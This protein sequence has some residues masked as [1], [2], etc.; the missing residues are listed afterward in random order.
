MGYIVLFPSFRLVGSFLFIPAVRL[1]GFI[2]FICFKYSL[3]LLQFIYS[4][5]FL[6]IYSNLFIPIYLFQSPRGISTFIIDFFQWSKAPPTTMSW[7]FIFIFLY[8]FILICAIYQRYTT[9][10]GWYG[11]KVY[12]VSNPRLGIIWIFTIFFQVFL[13]HCVLATFYGYFVLILL[14]F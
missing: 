2:S 8:V 7:R 5:L 14:Y 3:P 6:F 10:W 1:V 9:R 4:Y 12:I 13:F 11:A